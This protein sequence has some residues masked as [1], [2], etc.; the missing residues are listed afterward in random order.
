MIDDI[1]MSTLEKTLE[2]IQSACAGEEG[3]VRGV[4]HRVQRAQSED[5]DRDVLGG[6]T[7]TCVFR[8]ARF[9]SARA[10]LG[11]EE[12]GASHGS[13]TESRNPGRQ[14]RA[15]GRSL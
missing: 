1:G 12:T 15:S 6:R 11:T 10:A 14:I 3:G 7:S 9:L 2:K 4:D 5:K 13:S 8:S